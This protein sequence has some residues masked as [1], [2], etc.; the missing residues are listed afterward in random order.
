M[1]SKTRQAKKLL[2]NHDMNLLNDKTYK[3]NNR[4]HI[5]FCG[6]YSLLFYHMILLYKHAELL[7][8]GKKQSITLLLLIT[9]KLYLIALLYLTRKSVSG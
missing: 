8:E 1:A 3:K 6:I 7:Y 5:S 4:S 2:Y 9:Q